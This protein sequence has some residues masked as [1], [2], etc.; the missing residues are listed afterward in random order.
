MINIL[1]QLLGYFAFI[2]LAISLWVTNDIKFRWINSLGCL[3]F[4]CYGIFINAFPIVLT[5]AVL[6]AINIYF[7]FKIY[8]RQEKFDLVEF[9]NDAALIPKFLSFYRKD[10]EAY[11]PGFEMGAE[12]DKIRFVVLRDIVVA[13]LFVA[14]VNT[15]GDAFVKINYTVPKYRDYK[16]GRFLFDEGKEFLHN[17]GVRRII[18]THVHNKQ[19]ERFLKVMGFKKEKIEA[20]YCFIKL[21]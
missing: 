12:Q 14:T 1:A 5:N 8:R 10:I 4:V 13:N 15:D 7:L 2:F 6:L 21:I 17:K 19:H 3:S 18:Y 20:G 11:F 9:K 16:V